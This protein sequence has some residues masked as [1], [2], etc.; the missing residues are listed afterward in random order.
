M[1]E[2][3]YP[4][5]SNVHAI[6]DAVRVP[7][8]SGEAVVAVPDG[9]SET[10]AAAALVAVEPTQTRRPWRTTLRGLFQAFVG[11]AALAPAIAAA[12]EEATGYDLD[13][14]PFI[15][16]ALASCAAVT[17][18]MALPGVEDFL[19]RFLPFLAAEKPIK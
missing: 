11:L 16:V 1:A 2:S 10:G 18:V 12:V 19:A 15:V 13:G 8:R 5:P 7:P 3:P 4:V 9:E 17:R 6:G 14:V